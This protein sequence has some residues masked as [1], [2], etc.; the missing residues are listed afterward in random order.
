MK[1]FHRL[2]VLRGF[3]PQERGA[4]LYVGYHGCGI[5]ITA[6]STSC[7]IDQIGP[8]KDDRNGD[9]AAC[10]DSGFERS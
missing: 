7:L 3:L 4:V 9:R 8:S 2:D 6:P 1:A 5:F 10:W